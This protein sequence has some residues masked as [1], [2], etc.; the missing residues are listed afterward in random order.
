MLSMKTNELV[1]RKILS[2]KNEGVIQKY[3]KEHH[4][5]LSEASL[6]FEEMKKFLYICATRKGAFSPSKVIDDVWH[7]FLLFTRDYNDFCV[8]HF[9]KFVHHVP[10]V[11]VT[12][13]SKKINNANYRALYCHLVEEFG[14]PNE[15]TWH[16]PL[17]MTVSQNAVQLALA[18]GDC[19][20]SDG[21][22]NCSGGQGDC[23]GHSCSP[24][25]ACNGDE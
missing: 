19:T 24:D 11:E 20:G 23:S 5:S 18:S 4:V 3:S 6:R 8:S 2:Y 16:L 17:S 9:D 22:G 12:Q 10:D 7:T 14:Y 21:D 15:N 13:E 1:K 25:S